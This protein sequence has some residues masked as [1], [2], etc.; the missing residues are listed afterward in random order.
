MQDLGEGVKHFFPLPI[1][2]QTLN[3][4]DSNV[5]FMEKLYGWGLPFN[6]SA[7]G[8]PID[9]LIHVIHVAMFILGISWA[10]YLIIALVKFRSRPGH[11]A[12]YKPNHFKTP[13]YIEVA[14]VIFE[15]VLLVGFSFPVIQQVQQHFPDKTKALEV[16]VIAEQFAW[17]IH[18]PG[19]DGQFGRTDIKLITATN[20]IG[21]DRS[22]T[23]AKD[24]I[25]T[26]NQLHIPVNKPVIAHLSSK[27]VIHSFFLPVMRVKQD[28]IPGQEIPI[29]FEANK[30][31]EFE[32]ACAQLC[33]LGHYRMRGF[34]TVETE[35]EF[36]A[37][38]EKNAPKLLPPPQ[39]P[40]SPTPISEPV[41]TAEEVHL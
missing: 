31:G 23:E 11:K 40:P 36:Q 1:T 14:I 38:L 20:L 17:N 27:D 12:T 35:D 37:W 25:T 7:H 29:W 19:P 28:V 30:T 21:L 24:D 26:I 4:T 22:D 16:R 34:F 3:A 33:G 9:L 39:P 18:Y 32:I 6:A 15:A 8:A 13:T 2:S 41:Q 10:I 5:R